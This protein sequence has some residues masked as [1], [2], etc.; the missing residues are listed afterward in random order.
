MLAELLV[1]KGGHSAG[2][3]GA[4]K[5]NNKKTDKYYSQV[6]LASNYAARLSPDFDNEPCLHHPAALSD[7]DDGWLEL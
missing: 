2:R 7:G 4:K 5:V 3:G 1:T 6:W